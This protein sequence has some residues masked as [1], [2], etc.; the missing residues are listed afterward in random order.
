MALIIADII[1]YGQPS[2]TEKIGLATLPHD[3]IVQLFPGGDLPETGVD[4]LIEIPGI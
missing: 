1:R 2:T 4:S 3:A